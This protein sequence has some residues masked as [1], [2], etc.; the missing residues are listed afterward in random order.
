MKLIKASG[1]FTA[2]SLQKAKGR[3][4]TVSPIGELR[5]P[6]FKA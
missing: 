6:G 5:D 1:S 4:V 3:K 2:G